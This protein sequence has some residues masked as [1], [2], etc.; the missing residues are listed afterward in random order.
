MS[1][2]YVVWIEVEAFNDATMMNLS[3]DLPFSRTATFDTEA[4][5]V[6]FAKALHHAA[7]HLPQRE[8]LEPNRDR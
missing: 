8:E 2:Q 4:E 1:T 5:A 3:I 6:A 7:L